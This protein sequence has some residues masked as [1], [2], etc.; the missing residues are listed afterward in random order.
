MEKSPDT[1]TCT[2]LYLLY[3]LIMMLT[4]GLLVQVPFTLDALVKLC[5]IDQC[6]MM[7]VCMHNQ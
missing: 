6:Y 2:I 5:Y 4:T 7:E 1:I 3:L